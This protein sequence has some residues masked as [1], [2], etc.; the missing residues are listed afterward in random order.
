MTTNIPF[1]FEYDFEY[2][3]LERLTPLIRRITARNPSG[4]TFQGTGTYVIGNGD[5]AVIDPGPMVDEHIEALKTSLAGE[6]VTHILITHTHED[7][8]PAAAPL[9]V[10][11][12]T[13]TYGYGAHGAGRIEKGIPVQEGGDMDFIPDNLLRHGDCVSGNGWTLEAI[14][15][16]GH[17]SNHL[18]FALAEEKAL[19]TGDH[20]MG[21]ST[22]VIG[23][24]DGNMTEYIESLKLLL[25]RDDEIYWPTHGTCIKDVKTYVQ[26]FIDHRIA[27]EEQI[28]ECL[29]KG[30][31]KIPEMV[32][33]I[34]TETDPRMFGAAGHSVLAAMVRLVD[35]GKV[36]C[37]GEPSLSSGYQLTT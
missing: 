17:T 2:T 13:E 11:W 1:T 4:F 6:T 36:V 32:P 28:L 26:S 20:V 37:E 8:S 12:D 14:Y 16:P 18:C 23:P 27:R 15:T 35:V 5:V 33:V 30:I 10:Y 31:S 29:G 9:K 3:K 24:P 7:H 19:F 22:S 25:D 34:Y 21:W